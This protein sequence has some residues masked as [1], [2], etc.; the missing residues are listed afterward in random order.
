MIS[1]L[2][3]P[4]MAAIARASGMG[5]IY[6]VPSWVPEALF[7]IIIGLASSYHFGYWGYLGAVWSYIWMQSGHGAFYNMK[8]WQSSDSDRMQTIEKIVRPLFLK[9]GGNIHT[10]LYSWLCMGFKGLMIGLPLFPFGLF[11][12]LFW[13]AS[14]AI[15]D[16]VWGEW[17][18]GAFTGICIV[19]FLNL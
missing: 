14:Y 5:V 6:K 15:R 1:L 2:A 12:A 11:L 4:L 19:L 8:G 17:L 7:G 10:P 3:I 9:F 18:S 13:P 16:H